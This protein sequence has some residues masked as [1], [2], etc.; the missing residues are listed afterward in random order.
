[1]Y[2]Y[3]ILFYFKIQNSE[4][5]RQQL[6]G[7]AQGPTLGPSKLESRRRGG[8]VGV[9]AAPELIAP[10][11]PT[12]CACDRVG[13][14]WGPLPSF[15]S[16]KHSIG[17]KE[18]SVPIRPVGPGEPIRGDC[19]ARPRGRDP[20]QGWMR[21]APLPCGRVLPSSRGATPTPHQ[22]SPPGLA[23]GCGPPLLHM[24]HSDAGCA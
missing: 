21:A 5:G 11:P 6:T 12:E 14:H 7:K 3:F 24:M 15:I 22:A 13:C 20:G 9:G 1:M 19:E 8:G 10:P 18:A 4:S 16:Y 17:R 23:L 2:R